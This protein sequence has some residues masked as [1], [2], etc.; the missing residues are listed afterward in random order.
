MLIV[1]LQQVM[2]GQHLSE[3]EMAEVIGDMVDGHENAAQMAGFLVALRI[4]GETVAEITGAARAMRA[5]MRPV[6]LKRSPLID[7]CGT[8]GDGAGTFNIST[9][10]A[11]VVAAAGV[12]VAK[13]GNR[14]VSSRS[15]SAD[16]LAALGVNI[17]AEPAVVAHCIESL[18]LGF[19]F[20]P[21][22]HPAMANAAPVRKQ[23]GVRTLF[24]LLGP[25]TNPG[26]AAY[27]LM[28]VYDR[29][30][31]RP[32]AQVLGN[33][34]CRRAWVVHGHDG[35][36]EV[37][38]CDATS[39]AE[40]D[41]SRVIEHTVTPEDFGLQRAK[42]ADLQGGD[43]ADNAKRMRA[44]LAGQESGALR[45][46]VALNAG[47]ALHVAGSCD[48]VRQGVICAQDILERGRALPILSELIKETTGR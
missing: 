42:P 27:Q 6:T 32:I 47:A 25:L 14:A 28:G 34:G 35:Q 43:A 40:W 17:D 48:T 10:V 33:L 44:L 23:L 13:H 3:E 16:V 29:A 8:G 20:A 46:A 41:G 18:G 26:G 9:A 24:N 15:G 39:I 7:T 2:R 38:L 37:S 22:W 45:D 11:F 19:L 30:L 5:R 36:D 31:V 4:K 12:G 1:A 21:A